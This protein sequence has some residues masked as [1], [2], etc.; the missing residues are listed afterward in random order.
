VLQVRPSRP[1][2]YQQVLALAAELR[3]Q[4]ENPAHFNWSPEALASELA[5]ATTWVAVE[6]ASIVSF[7]CYRSSFEGLEI[8]VL[9]TALGFRRQGA[10]SQLLQ[11]LQ[12]HAAQSQKSVRLEVHAQNIGARKLYEKYGFKELR[13]RR[14]YYSDGGDALEL[15]WPAHKAGC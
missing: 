10:Q 6:R 4:L 2:D 5:E 15:I 8:S 9:G 3:A 1:L 7:V 12:A 13:R 14:S 11:S